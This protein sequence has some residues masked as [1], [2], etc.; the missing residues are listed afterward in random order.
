M[1]NELK[2]NADWFD[3]YEEL[4]QQAGQKIRE[5]DPHDH[6]NF[7]LNELSSISTDARTNLQSLC[8]RTQLLIKRIETSNSDIY[9]K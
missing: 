8:A 5:V 1:K 7:R 2:T 9:G 4:H 3:Y 6:Q